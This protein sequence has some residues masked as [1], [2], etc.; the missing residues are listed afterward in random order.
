MSAENMRANSFG[1][2]QIAL[3]RLE[4]NFLPD[5]GSETLTMTMTISALL[6]FPLIALL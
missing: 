2:A 5:C 3:L 4:A 1:K 6:L